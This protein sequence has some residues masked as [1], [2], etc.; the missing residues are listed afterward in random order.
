MLFI[1]IRAVKKY[2]A[3]SSDSLR[4]LWFYLHFEM[5]FCM[6]KY[7]KKKKQHTPALQQPTLLLLS[8]LLN[9]VYSKT[10]IIF[11]N[12]IAFVNCGQSSVFTS[13]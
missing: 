2:F 12:I 7:L 8:S 6:F 13:L 5:F 11:T 9:P 10:N 3:L 4:K 1:Y